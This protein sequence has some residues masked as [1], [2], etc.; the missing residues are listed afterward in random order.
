[1]MAYGMALMKIHIIISFLIMS[2]W[3]SFCVKSDVMLGRRAC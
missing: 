2:F 1:M 3:L